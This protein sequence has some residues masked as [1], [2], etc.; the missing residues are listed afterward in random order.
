MPR[1]R[2]ARLSRERSLPAHCRVDGIRSR[3]PVAAGGPVAAAFRRKEQSACG[4][5]DA[6]GYTS[7]ECADGAGGRQVRSR[8]LKHDEGEGRGGGCRVGVRVGPRGIEP[9]AVAGGY[10]GVVVADVER[11]GA[12]LDGE[13]F[14]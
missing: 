9:G 1:V 11:D 14:E 13:E 4:S 8:G 2:I 6:N 3:K 12:G 10:F 7:V 5:E